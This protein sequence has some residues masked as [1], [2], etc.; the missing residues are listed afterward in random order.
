[1]LEVTETG[2]LDAARS[3]DTLT[4]LQQLGCQLAIDDFG[5][6]YSSL[7]RLVQLPAHVLKIDQ[8]FVRE[9]HRDQQSVAVIAA[10]LTLARNLRKTVVAEGVEDAASLCVL[11]DLGCDYA[12]GFHLGLPQPP[13]QLAA[14]L[15]ASSPPASQ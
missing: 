10:V 12:Q 9:L 11:E 7:S 8:S 3:A 2:M 15:T 5:T 13:D 4:A 6:G 1:M 14:H